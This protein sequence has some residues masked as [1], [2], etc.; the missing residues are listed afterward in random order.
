MGS[1]QVVKLRDR[2][3]LLKETAEWFD[4]KWHLSIPL[5]EESIRASLT[6]EV[7]IPQWYVILNKAD[8]IIGGAGVIE[9]DF[10]DRPDLS[11]NLCALFVENEHR[12]QG[13]AKVLLSEIRKDMKKMGFDTLYLV[14][15]HTSFYE[16]YGWSFLTMVQDEDGIPTRLYQVTTEE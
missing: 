9:N 3:T 6:T 13:I 5:Y 11:P 1:Y 15:D 4:S 14:T 8:K 12:N 7:G 16:R 10:H 2:P